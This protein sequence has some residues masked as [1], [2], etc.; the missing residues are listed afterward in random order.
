MTVIERVRLRPIEPSDLPR[1]YELQLDP[2][3]N[4]MAATIPRTREAFDAHW[5]KSVGDP[6]NTS[7][8]ILIGDEFVGYIS[9]FPVENQHHL[10]YWIDRS[11]W[12]MGIASRAL[13]LFLNEVTQRPL[14]ATVAT[15]NGASLRVLHKNGF[16]VERTYLQPA[17]ERY[18][19][20]EV[21]DLVLS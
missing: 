12:G 8:A 15:R 5:P 6:A 11:F 4:R 13:Q 21:A 18:P 19:E 16:V 17:S 9:R 1:M 2:E 10:G 14:I 20:S 3:S 7:R